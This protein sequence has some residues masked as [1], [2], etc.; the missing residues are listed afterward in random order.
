MTPSIEAWPS[1][2]AKKAT[3][4]IPQSYDPYQTPDSRRTCHLEWSESRKVL[5]LVADDTAEVLDIIDHSDIIG[6]SIEVSLVDSA[7]GEPRATSATQGSGDTN[8]EPSSPTPADTQGTSTLVIYAYPRKDTSEDSFISCGTKSGSSSKPVKEYPGERKTD[9]LANRQPRHR[10]FQVAPCEDLGFVSTVVKSIRSLA[11][12][13]SRDDERILVLVNPF[14]G[15][16]MGNTIYETIVGPMLEQAGVQHDCVLTTH[17]GHGAELMAKKVGPGEDGIEDVSKYDGIVAVGGDGS[18]YEI[19]QGIKQRSDCDD[20]LS[21]VKLGHIGAGTSN[22]LSASLAHAS[23]EKTTATD[24]SFMVAK[25]NTV[26][27]D[28]SRYETRSQSYLSFLT[29]SWSIIADI[30]IESEVLRWLGWLRMDVYSVW[31]VLNLRSYRAKLTYLKPESPRLTELPALTEPLPEEQGWETM[32]AEF[33][34]FWT[35]QVTHAGEALFNHPQCKPDD[36][37]FHIFIVKKPISRLRMALILLGLEHGGHVGMTG[38]EFVEC[39][40]YRLEPITPGSFNDLD[41]E[42]IEAG[43]VQGMVLPGAIQA[44]CNL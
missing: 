26:K 36:G 40:A 2:D 16:R 34:L 6:A 21:R 19:M 18:V 7:T 31:R 8:N 17:S 4:L 32:E 39:T 41:G 28:L 37:L 14:S 22:G 35:S 10:H 12:P 15:R 20:I 25:G 13:D 3:L 30:D 5:T 23:Q 1:E 9:T 29:F 43:P 33:C 24:Y 44:Y 27:M 11:R 38:V 42:V